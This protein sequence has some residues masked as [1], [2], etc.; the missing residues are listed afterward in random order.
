MCT[1]L[2]NLTLNSTSLESSL[3]SQ[4][5]ALPSTP[6]NTPVDG[7]GHALT[8]LPSAGQLTASVYQL[9]ENMSEVDFNLGRQAHNLKERARR[10]RSFQCSMYSSWIFCKNLS[11][12]LFGKYSKRSLLGSWRTPDKGLQINS[13]KG[14]EKQCY[15]NL[16]VCGELSSGRQYV[17]A[18]H[19]HTPRPHG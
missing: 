13:P 10:Y 14:W 3:T 7:R 9:N 4:D 16:Q 19:E 18:F 5:S 17:H 1:T 2:A 6:N 15:K 8:P 12:Y 11:P